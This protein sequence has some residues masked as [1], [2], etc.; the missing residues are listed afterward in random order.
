MVRQSLLVP[1]GL[2]KN[3]FFARLSFCVIFRQV[4]S[5]L[6]V[7]ASHYVNLEVRE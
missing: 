5:S 3:R 7:A 4:L 6:K 1:T 2:Q